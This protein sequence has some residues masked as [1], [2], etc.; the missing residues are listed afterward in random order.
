[1]TTTEKPAKDARKGNP[2]FSAKE[3][4]YLERQD[5][6]GDRVF[7]A[8]EDALQEG[9]EYFINEYP[10]MRP[11]DGF[12]ADTASSSQIMKFRKIPKRKMA[13][14][15]KIVRSLQK[16]MRESWD[17]IDPYLDNLGAK[18]FEP[19][20]G[21]WDE[22]QKFVSKKWDDVFIG[23]T[24]MP[25]EMI[26]KNKFTL[27]RY[28]I[29]VCQEMKKDKIDHAPEFEAGKEVMRV[30]GSLGLVVNDI[31]KWLRK[32]GIRCQSNH[33]LGGLANTPSLAGKAGMGWL[34]RSGM[35]IT[36]E[37]G[38]RQRIA[39]VF[40]EH[41]YFEFTDNRNHDWIEEYCG[42]CERC[43]K[44]CPGEAIYP[45]AVVRFDN[46]PGVDTM[47]TCIDRDKCFPYFSE[48]IGCSICVKVCPFSRAGDTYNRLKA[49]V[50]KNSIE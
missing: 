7:S 41:K 12:T 26:F 6:F 11:P 16:G 19:K 31:A 50:E 8:R 29:V 22:L 28:A 39:P 3:F 2:M 37:Y 17:G 34:G 47:R 13:G 45:K 30:Y 18:P 36:R 10:H 5:E 38:P 23:F 1:L 44:A 15:L 43:R 40:V 20:P 33:P 27:F 9:F 42:M 49:V 48:T 46:V 4:E 21:L 32:K 25:Q 24:E 35:L 14:M